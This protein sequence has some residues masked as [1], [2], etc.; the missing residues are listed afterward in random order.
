MTAVPAVSAMPE[1]QSMPVAAKDVRMEEAPPREQPRFTVQKMRPWGCEGAT[2]V[3]SHTPL[4]AHFRGP[5]RQQEHQRQHRIPIGAQAVGSVLVED[6]TVP[7]AGSSHTEKEADGPKCVVLEVP[8]YTARVAHLI[9]N[10]FKAHRRLCVM[11]GGK[12][13]GVGKFHH[14]GRRRHQP[15]H[16]ASSDVVADAPVTIRF[17][18]V[19]ILSAEANSALRC[20]TTGEIFIATFLHYRTAPAAEEPRDGTDSATTYSR[21]RR[22]VVLPSS[23]AGETFELVCL[24][25]KRSRD[26]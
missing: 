20:T 1:V 18:D 5:T 2:V 16:A 15:P 26:E 11:E 21:R 17:V 13:A 10:M 14:G 3:L 12:V 22:V 6:R 9:P 25:L 19:G 7:P 23:A 4:H 8:L 24:S